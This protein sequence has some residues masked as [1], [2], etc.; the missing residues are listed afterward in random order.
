[1][2]HAVQV[3]EPTKQAVLEAERMLDGAGIANQED[4][5]RQA[6]GQ[7]LYNTSAVTLRDLPNRASLRQLR[8]DVCALLRHTPRLHIRP[9]LDS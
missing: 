8:A 4:A 9:D 3:L 5:L 1:M 7:A 6:S 2:A